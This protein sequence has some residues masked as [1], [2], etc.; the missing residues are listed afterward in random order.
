MASGMFM[1]IPHV[2]VRPDAERIT[3]LARLFLVD[4]DQGRDQVTVAAQER[5][6]V[7]RIGTTI[8]YSVEPDSQAP[9]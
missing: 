6:G 4:L 5:G 7:D 2:S 1:P 9:P 3:A 8:G